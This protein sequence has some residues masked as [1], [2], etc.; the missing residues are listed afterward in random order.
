MEIEVPTSVENLTLLVQYVIITYL[1][2]VGYTSVIL[3]KSCAN[4]FNPVADRGQV[5]ES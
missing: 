3:R 1:N 2:Q 4:Y 5:S